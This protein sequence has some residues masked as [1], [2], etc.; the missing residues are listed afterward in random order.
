[1]RFCS[2]FTLVGKMRIFCGVLDLYRDLI[3]HLQRNIAILL[4][5][6]GSHTTWSDWEACSVKYFT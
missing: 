5:L 6:I 2:G 1:M 4:G 3:S